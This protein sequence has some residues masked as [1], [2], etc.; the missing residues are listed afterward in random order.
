VLWIHKTSIP[1]KEYGR[2]VK[3]SFWLSLLAWRVL[4][5]PATSASPER[6]GQYHDQEAL[7]RET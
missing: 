4:S 2:G 5:I 6:L 3:I 7:Q 1:L